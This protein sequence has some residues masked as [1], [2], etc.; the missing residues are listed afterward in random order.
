MRAYALRAAALVALASGLA[1]AALRDRPL[2]VLLH[3]YGSH[4]GDL[5]GLVPVK[6][7]PDM[8][9]QTVGVFVALEV[10]TE[11]GKASDGHG[12]ILE[13]VP[14]KLHAR[15]PLYIGSAHDVEAVEK[16]YARHAG[17]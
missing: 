5:F 14:D 15:T 3:G 2:L 4:E 13:M 9:G 11:T 17:R 6:V 16:I 8:V 1:T 12:R 10:K 7:T